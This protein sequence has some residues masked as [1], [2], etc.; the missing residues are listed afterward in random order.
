MKFHY[1]GKYS[2]D[3]STL[4][5]RTQEGAVQYR[6]PQDMKRFAIWANVLSVLIMAVCYAAACLRAGRMISSLTGC[7]LSVVLCVPHEFLHALWFPGDVYM[8]QNLSQGMLF[9]TGPGDFS[10]FRFI[11]MSLFPN[12]VFGLLPFL[13]FLVFPSQAWLGMLG[14]LSIGMGAGDYM[15][16]YNCAVQVP[17]GGMT[18]M[19]GMHSWWYRPQ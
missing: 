16:V 7:L 12:L 18:F 17:A 5:Q 2:G 10:K 4:P 3:E 6:E 1:S 14:A 19:S 13:L 15:N 8:Y 9:V 11:M